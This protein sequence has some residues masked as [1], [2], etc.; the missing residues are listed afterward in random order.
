MD[1]WIPGHYETRLRDQPV[2]EVHEKTRVVELIDTGTKTWKDEVVRGAVSNE[3]ALKVLNVP[4][5]MISRAYEMRWPYE[6]GRKV[7]T[8]SFYRCIRAQ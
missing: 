3:E 6:R 5:S 2:R 7:T 1:A 8:R 4:I